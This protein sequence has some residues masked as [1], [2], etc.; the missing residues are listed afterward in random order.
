M[1][2]RRCFYDETESVGRI[3]DL[4]CFKVISTWKFRKMEVFVLFNYDILKSSCARQIL[5]PDLDSGKKLPRGT[6]LENISRKNEIFVNFYSFFE[7]R[8]KTSSW[9]CYFLVGF[10]FKVSKYTRIAGSQPQHSIL[11]F[12]G[13]VLCKLYPAPSS[14]QL[15]SKLTDSNNFF[16][17]T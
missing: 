9:W 4:S 5:R 1:R 6:S 2:F 3:N 15:P 17:T 8:R 14:F 7:S 16:P 13:H 12:Y 10:V 11:V